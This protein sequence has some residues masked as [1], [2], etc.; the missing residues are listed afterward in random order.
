MRA[1][2][3]K[4][5]QDRGCRKGLDPRDLGTGRPTQGLD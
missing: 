4:E 3:A 5:A 1:R 2:E